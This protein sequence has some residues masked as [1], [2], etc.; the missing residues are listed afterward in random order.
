MGYESELGT[1]PALDPEWALY[2]QSIIGI[3]QW[4]CEIGRID[5]AME[6][7]LLLSHLAYQH[8][9]HLD[10]DLHI[11][12]YLKFKHNSRLSCGRNPIGM[13]LRQ[14]RQMLLLRL[15]RKLT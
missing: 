11:I 9:G 7:S 15:G 2:Y 12:G 13:P 6:V 5:I 4:M 8:K 14:S 1:T 3:M 10:A